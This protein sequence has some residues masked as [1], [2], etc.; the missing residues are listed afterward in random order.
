MPDKV[1]FRLHLVAAGL[2]T[3]D[4]MVLDTDYTNFA[5]VWNCR[6]F[7]MLGGVFRREFG[8]ILGREEGLGQGAYTK[9]EQALHKFGIKT[10]KFEKTDRTKC[11]KK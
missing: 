1:G 3:E 4:Y 8:W 10:E 9:A 6:E 5:T 11:L 7:H 2:L